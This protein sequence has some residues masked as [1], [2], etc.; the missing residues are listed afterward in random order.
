MKRKLSMSWVT[1]LSICWAAGRSEEQKQEPVGELQRKGPRDFTLTNPCQH[2]GESCAQ[3]SPLWDFSFGQAGTFGVQ[4]ETA[5]GSLQLVSTAASSSCSHI[6]DP[7][8][9]WT[10]LTYTVGVKVT[11]KAVVKSTKAKDTAHGLCKK[12]FFLL[13]SHAAGFHAKMIHEVMGFFLFFFLHVIVLFAKII[14]YNK[15]KNTTPVGSFSESARGCKNILVHLREFMPLSLFSVAHYQSHSMK[16]SRP[17]VRL[18]AIL[19]V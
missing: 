14:L 9:F 5:A 15:V 8:S 3:P 13:G 11:R 17:F 12:Q 4:S 2:K 10:V 7:W 6:L 18:V 19:S 1:S 16:L